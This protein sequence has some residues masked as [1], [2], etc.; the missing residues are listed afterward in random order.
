M[1]VWIESVLAA[2][3]CARADV[4]AVAFGA[5]PG[6]FTGLRVAA[7]VAQA[8]GYSLGIPV[9]RVSTLAALAAAALR[10]SGA[11]E[12]VV[13]MDARMGEVY[14]GHYRCAA[15]DLLQRVVPDCLVAVAAGPLTLP[16]GAI[17]AGSGFAVA[18]G[19]LAG[20][21]GPV[22]PELL[23]AATDLLELT[24]QGPGLVERVSP[25]AAVPAYLRER[26]TR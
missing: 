24:A 5:G 2:A 7:A 26:V 3:R 13:A 9:L 11:R 12:A 25:S 22:L 6:S 21:H 14:V 1:Y 10:E 20:W 16:P 8:L 17:A 18:P 23:P 4:Q 15:G 19:L